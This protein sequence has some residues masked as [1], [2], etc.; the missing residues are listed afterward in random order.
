MR[1]PFEALTLE[2][3]SLRTRITLIR[4]LLKTCLS[5]LVFLGNVSALRAADPPPSNASTVGESVTNPVTGMSTTVSALITDPAGTP[6]AGNTAFVRT[7]D[8]YVFLV[9]AVNEIV[10]NNDSPPLGFKIISQDTMAQTVQLQ[11]QTNP[12]SATNATLG[13]QILYTDLQAQF[14]G[15]D[16]TGSTPP[17]VL[18]AGVNGVRVVNAGS[19]GSNGRNGALFVP[20]HSGGN[21]APGP[22]ASYTTTFNISTTNKIGLEVGSLGGNGG[23]GGNSY[24]SFWSG[25]DGGDGGAGGPVTAINDTGFQ[26]ATTG[27][28]MYGIFAYSRSGKAGDGGGGFA[29][30]G[31]GTGGHSSDGGTVTVE[32]RGTIITVGSGAFGIYGLSVSNNGGDGGDTW[33]LVGQSGAGNYG[34]NGGTVTIT[35]SS[36]GSIYTSGSFAHGI[37][38]Q[39]IGGSGGSSGTSGNLLVSL[40]GSPDNGGNGGDVNV[41]NYGLISTTGDNSRGIF[42]QSIGGGGGSGGTVGGLISVG[43][44]GSNGGSSGTVVVKNQSTGQI[45]TTG[46]KSDGIFAQSVGGSGGSGSNSFGL[47]AVGGSGSNAGNGGAVTVENYGLISTTNNVSRGIVAQSIGGGGGDGGSSGG[48]VSVGGS[49]N[50]GGLGA[51]VT[52]KNGGTITTTGADS[53]GI[54]AQ[55]VGGGGGNGGSSGSVGLFAGVGIG[56]NGGKGGTGGDV[57]LTLQGQDANTASLISTGGDRSTGVFAQS[58][59][60]GGGNGGGAV[61]VSVGFDAAASFAIGGKGGVAGDGGLVTLNKGTGISIIDTSG[62]DSTGVFLQSVG[63][64]GGNGGYAISVAASGG[65]SSGSL[66][67]AIGGA[68]SKGGAGGDV[69]VGAF[70]SSGVM[71]S[72]GFNGTILTTGDRSTG[73]M[74]Q[75]VGGGGGNG[76]LAVAAAG[77][78]G[79]TLSGSISIGLGGNGAGGGA[80]GTVQVGTQGNITTEGNSSTALLVQSIGGGGG[81]GGGSIAASLA[82][83]GG[84]GSFGISL[85]GDAGTASNGGNVNVATRSGTITT[86]GANSTGILIQ[87]V[88]GGGG[89]GGYAISAGAAVGAVGAGAV[90]VGLGGKGGGGGNGGNVTADLQSNVETSS[91]QIAR[92]LD[93]VTGQEIPAHYAENATGVLVQS[94]GGGGGNGGFSVASGVALA[95]D[96]SGAV[97]VGLGGKGATGGTGGT[98]NVTSTGTIST[99][100]NKSAGLVAQSIGGGGGNGGYN[101][102]VAGAGASIGSGAVGIGLGGSAGSGN[103]GGDV[104]VH[105]LTGKI[106][107]VGNDS[108]GVLAQS[109]GGGGGNGGYDV[110]VAASGAGGGSGAVSVG[111]GGSGG[112][113]ANAG[114]VHLT[115]DNNVSTSGK[116]SAA[117]VA[118]AIGGGGGSGGYNVSLAGSGAGSGSGAVGIGLGGS[119]SSGGMGGEVTLVVNGNI[120]TVLE[121]SAGVMAQSIGG[122][123][124]NGGF[125]LSLTGSGGSTSGAV[126]VGLGGSGSGGGD[127]LKVDATSTGTIHTLGAKSAGFVAQSIGGGGGN[128]GFNV[129]VGVSGGTASG[130]VTVGLGGSG[131]GGGDGGIVIGHTSG[132]ITTEGDKSVG[133]LAQ[134]IGGGGGNGGFDVSVAGSLSN[135]GSGAVSVGLGGSG[136]GGGDAKSVTLTVNNDVI[137]KGKKST[138]I[139]A[140]S[141]GG[142]G[143]NGGFDVTAPI[144]ASSTLSGAIGVSLGGSAGTG[145]NA[146]IV[147]SNVTGTITTA[148]EGS[149]GMLAQSLGGGGGNGGMSIVGALSFS[150]SGSGAISVGLGGSGGNGGNAEEV[151]STLVGNVYTVAKDSFG[152][153]AQSLGGG[154]GTGGLSVS[155]AISMAKTGS[156]ALAFGLGGAGG[157]GGDAALVTNTVTGYV[158]T[159][160][161]YSPG[162]LAQSMGGGGGNGGLNVSGIITASQEGS[163]GLAIGIGGLGGDGGD[164]KIVINTVTGGVVTTGD[165]SDAIVA[166]SLGGGGGNG[167]INVT[168]TINATEDGGGTLGIGVGGFGGGG[169]NA[170]AVTSTITTTSTYNLIGTTGNNSSGVVAQSIG[171]GGGNGGLNVTGAINLTGKSGAAIGLGLGGFGGGGG[172]SGVVTVDVTG[173]IITQGNGS[174][175]IVAQSIAGGG[176]NGGTNVTGTLAVTQSTGGAAT[177]AAI[178]LGVGGFGGKG[179]TAKAVDVTFD[180]LIIARP[181]IFHAA[182]GGNPAYIEYVDGSGSN[183]IVAQSIGGGGG[184][185]GLDVSAGISYAGGKGDG[186]G[187]VA[188]VGGFGGAGGDADTT[189]VTVI[190]S[191]SITG[192]GAGKSA[193]LAQSIGGGG[194]A[195]GMNVTGGITSD[196]ALLVGVGGFGGNAGVGKTVTVNATTDVYAS[197]LNSMEL[198]SAG[199]MAQSIGGGG[200]NGGMNVTGGLELSKQATLPSIN[201]GIGGFG[202][203]GASSGDVNVTLAGN[204]TTAGDWVHG[205]LAQSIAGGGGNGALNVGGQLNFA[206]SENAGGKTDVSI[207]AGVG[208]NAGAGSI[209]GDVTVIDNGIISTTGAYARGIEAQSIGGGGGNGGMN[210]TAIYTKSSNPITVGV[211]GSGGGGGMAGMVTVTRGGPL[212]STGTITT[213]GLGAHGIEASSLG[214]G[215]GD[216]GM[217]FN[218]GFSSVGENSA[219]PG[220]AAN[221]IIGGDGASAGNGSTVTV[222]NYSTIIT[223]KDSSDGI[224]AQSIGGG[225]GNGNFNVGV[226]Y[227]NATQSG[228]LYNRPNQNMGF[229]LG[230]GGST[231]NGGQ[232]GDVTVTQVGDITTTGK[233]SFGI[234]AQ[235]IG[236]GGG[237]AGLDIAAV[238]ASGGKAGITLGTN[239]GTGGTGGTVILNYTGNLNTTGDGAMGLLAQSLG[240]GGGNSSS[241]TI[242]GEAP[243]S[244]NDL[245]QTRPQIASMAFGLTGG[246]GGLGGTVTLNSNG[247]IT[248]HGKRA[249]GAMAQSIGGGGGNGG[250]ANTFGISAA[251]ASLTMG[252]TGGTGG[253][254][255]L[256]TLTNTA[257]VQTFG[258]ESAGLFAQS[259]GGGGGNGG[260]VFSGGAKTGDTGITVALGGTGGVGNK[261]GDVNVT[262]DG[263]VVTKGLAAHAIVAQSIGGGGG[264]GGMAIS[265]TMKLNTAS[266]ASNS[267]TRASI[268][269]GGN[270]GSGG[271]GGIVTV[272]NHGGLGTY[273]DASVG[274][275]AQSIGGGGG[276]GRSVVTGSLAGSQGNSLSISVGGTGG[277]GGTGGSVIVKNQLTSDPNSAKIIT[278]GDQSHGILA[279]SI[280]GGG[281]TGSSVSTFNR[282]TVVS[283][284]T[285]AN[286][287]GLSIGGNGGTGGK[288][289]YVEVTNEGSIETHGAGAHGIIA[290]S[291]GGGGGQGGMATSG[292]MAFGSMTSPPGGK[293]F[294]IAV[295]GQGG[296]GNDGGN[297]VVTNSGSIHVYGDGSYGV[298]AQSIGGGGGNGG[299]AASFSRDLLTNPKTNFLASVSNFAIGGFGGA[300][301][302]GGNVTVTNTGSITVE[303]KNAYGIFAQSVAGGG[304]NSAMSISSPVWMAS[305]FALNTLL[306]GQ[307][308][309]GTTGTV[310]IR[311]T[312]DITMLGSNSIAQLA[313]NVNGGG[314]NANQFLDFSQQAANLDPNG[315]PLHGAGGAVDT[316]TG[317]VLSNVQLGAS[318]VTSAGASLLDAVHLGSFHTKGDNSNGGLLQSIGGGGGRGTQNITMANGSQIN[319]VLALGGTDVSQSSGGTVNYTQTGD[320]TTTGNQSTGLG[321]QS[322]G[323]GGGTEFVTL[324]IVPAV[325]A[326]SLMSFAPLAFPA[327]PASSVSLGGSGGAQND[328]G[329][330]N[331]TLGGATLATTGD[332]SPGLLLQSIGAGGGTSFVLGASALNVD[333]GGKNGASGNGLDITVTQT[334][335]VSTTGVLSSGIVVQSIGGGGGALFTDLDPS[336]IFVSPNSG[337]TGN[338]GIINFTQ[339]G[340]VDATGD[341]STGVI[342]QSLGGG[343]GIVD[344][345]FAGSAGGVGS[346]GAITFH[347]NGTIIATGAGGTGIFAQSQGSSG[348]GNIQVDLATGKGIFFGTG[349][350][351]VHFSGGATNLFTNNGTIAG[352]EDVNGQA[353]LGED[354]NDT[355]QNNGVFVGSANFGTG[356]NQFNNAS[357]A[358]LVLGP[359][360]LLGAAGNQ[361]INDGILRPGG[362]GL[363]QHTDMTGSFIQSGTGT[364]FNELDF[365]TDKIDNISM[366]G[367]AKLGGRIDV[368]LLNPQ[369]IPIGHFQKT[370]V[371]ADS[372]VTNDGAVLTTLPS[373]VI[374]YDLQ[375]PSPG[376]DAV[377]DY[378]IDFNP[379]GSN[380]GRNLVEVGG[381]IDNIQKAGSSPALAPTIIALI[382]APTMDVY[383]NLLSQLGPD[384]YGEQQAEMLR[385]TQRFGETILN[386]GSNRYSLKDRMIWFDFLGSNTVHS[387]YDDYKTVRQQTLGFALGFEDMINA[388]WSAGL[389]VS[390]ED[391]SANG[392]QGRWN[393]NGSSERFGSVLR[394]K[395][396]GSELA[397]MISFGWNSMGSTRAGYVAYPFNS[398]VNRDMQVITAMVRYAHEF[399]ADDFYIKP[400]V[401]LGVTHLSAGAAT[402]HGGATTNLETGSPSATNLA[403]L[404]YYETHAWVRPAV[405]VRKAIIVT[406]TTRISLHT[407]MGYQYYINGNNTYVRA[408]FSGAPAGV[409]PMNVPIGLG[410]MASLSVGMQVLIM[411]DLSFGLYY[412]KALSKHY[413]LDLYNFRFNKSF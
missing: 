406:N 141:V 100:G 258:E 341:R 149:G 16:T 192:Y 74:A 78:A 397:A 372:G 265:T 129:S 155:G 200:G 185:G 399:V 281:G 216:A 66:S 97:S 305:N 196:S 157:K 31:G 282:A 119:G 24:A 34:G 388:R 231:G 269:I 96:G 303:G 394:Y 194:G 89:N 46:V 23:H 339:N 202:G 326:F 357:N 315:N 244:Q 359:Q 172:Y 101:I 70:N 8:G 3:T 271:D 80:G 243:S 45:Y 256:V 329:A 404:G 193:I 25:R 140:Q 373:V 251:V 325:P 210:V 151:T 180:G 387:A 167:G 287:L 229:S 148:D 242:S 381:Y 4:S 405:T 29:A 112:T 333:I 260:S 49:G 163:D 276:N 321:V 403:L 218:V 92:A 277:T 123:G 130:A 37:L 259:I 15:A 118:Q 283:G 280:G 125:N 250:N 13:Y 402:E 43:G 83:G 126:S 362:T 375:Y 111:L 278:L 30:P 57:N 289:G 134:S 190:G 254:G 246:L 22:A 108:I 35:N 176:G 396:N 213:N 347:M 307:G 199:I 266:P 361:L 363:A 182:A 232:G 52:V 59:G 370:L 378:N 310:T 195:G 345:I 113:G 65:A 383:R 369:L 94:V 215:G 12:V 297:V 159:Q 47:V 114:T 189:T 184:Q 212:A 201:L 203:A 36:T 139:I 128:G 87:S 156:G 400:Q 38:A 395:N 168:G 368:A 2:E 300:G 336:M 358:L 63:G 337:N 205:I 338:G 143:G 90:N 181:G 233:D 211:G 171:G 324:Q 334:R 69:T 306:G 377:L 225:G 170:E 191:Q 88:G 327:P 335:D 105:T 261:G 262:N 330:I 98:V 115:V 309:A 20:P 350:T 51:L 313:Q 239:G 353:F 39:S 7:A 407:E 299:F 186:Y 252:G 379:P 293:T 236:G 85:G 18:V 161:S 273:L 284:T 274:I 352:L 40:S 351:G 332:R 147:T 99:K 207:I 11:A 104:T 288:G 312:G 386:G 221:F 412:T 9:K 145:G 240:N 71:T 410:S 391:N 174:D 346:A 124:G 320:V 343:G 21:G 160:G 214:G 355:F 384:F 292:Q 67:L 398:S 5:V 268:N 318:A 165:H 247:A 248:T 75:S 364:T 349:G 367:T 133:I 342:L 41:F 135:S 102:T 389:A 109:I 77:S 106:T 86:Q 267:A 50:G 317:F 314:G 79:A 411:N 319:L 187:I 209:A 340:N 219:R 348:Q 270:G 226:T 173:K 26:I 393:A 223:K 42:A 150:G 121:N 44:A 144:S 204:A 142:G 164:G 19:N 255:G 408:G 107:T 390:Y 220:F 235:S 53:I 197:A 154:G 6:T 331:L 158:Q 48:M 286:Q 241:T 206:A 328:G 380:F 285:S 162:I 374:T 217:N 222:T 61:T 10:Y 81:N 136:A 153:I 392:Y 178:S 316:A 54:V 33:G 272:I 152:V 120:D 117:V 82:L 62:T 237:D 68:G 279:M 228:A 356:T 179:G 245:G 60:G 298:Y 302:D 183:G 177:T 234:L 93:P 58:V 275:L 132:N 27:D 344:D 253:V 137:T 1:A 224:L 230:V 116:N 366:T 257:L 304:G 95:G 131:A 166:Q 188:G 296:S 376:K 91:V 301:G 122:G 227:A 354:G 264:T 73:F 323:G 169:G 413:H 360:F 409:D 263:I 308:S 17:P 127:A 294:Q 64:G 175:G 291:I 290:E 32:N 76:G 56:G 72:T 138:G 401:D 249:F 55:S 110:S 365:G 198:N 146:G 28:D 382:Y 14:L 311:S 84:S 385:G 103:I 238:S 322:I 295:G 371:H 208:G